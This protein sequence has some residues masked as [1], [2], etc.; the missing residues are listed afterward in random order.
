MR[1]LH[2][3]ATSGLRFFW[4][5]ACGLIESLSHCSPWW[6]YS[7]QV[8]RLSTNTG[9]NVSECFRSKSLAQRIPPNDPVATCIN[10]S[11]LSPSNL[12]NKS[13][14]I[15]NWGLKSGQTWW[16]NWPP[17]PHFRMM[18]IQGT[19]V[20]CSPASPSPSPR[21]EQ[22]AP[23]SSPVTAGTTAVTMHARPLPPGWWES[24]SV[25]LPTLTLYSTSVYEQ[26]FSVYIVSV[27]D[28]HNRGCHSLKDSLI[29]EGNRSSLELCISSEEPRACVI[30]VTKASQ[31]RLF[32][33]GFFWKVCHS[34]GCNI[35]QRFHQTTFLHLVMQLCIKAQLR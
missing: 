20:T 19:L 28:L 2:P 16:L 32:V 6:R 27:Y 23:L 18:G 22:R 1:Q 12:V 33:S 34:N 30:K 26:R 25:K 5:I 4:R 10:A 24:R 7:K 17:F 8:G 9:Q 31:V 21:A 13:S 11:L 29:T 3:T 15:I 14:N 35:S